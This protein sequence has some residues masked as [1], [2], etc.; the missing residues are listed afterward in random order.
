MLYDWKQL[1]TIFQLKKIIENISIWRWMH[2]LNGLETTFIECLSQHLQ[3]HFL[4]FINLQ[5]KENY[6]SDSSLQ[7]FLT[8]F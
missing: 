8:H 6:I 4:A 7:N 2:N 5:Y 1:K 3:T